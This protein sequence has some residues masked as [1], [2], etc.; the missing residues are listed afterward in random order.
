MLRDI[1]AVTDDGGPGRER[2]AH[3]ATLG[4]LTRGALHE[5]A[6]PLVALLGSAEL[7]LADTTPGTKVH[8]RVEVVHRT[9][10]EIAE[11]VRALQAYARSVSAPAE[12]LSLAE[13]ARTALALV[14]RVS[15]APDIELAARIQSESF[16]HAA[17]GLVQQRLVDLLLDAIAGAERG[18][19]V[20]LFVSEQEGE[21]VAAVGTSELRLPVD[22]A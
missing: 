11:I 13:A 7:A 15:A 21:A 10:T 3:L 4:R 5:I 6:N 16:V 1:R 18:D 9:G 2:D 22:P 8:G 12:R 20:E 19:A 14:E 17:P